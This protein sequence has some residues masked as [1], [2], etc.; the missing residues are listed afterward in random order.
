[1]DDLPFD[2]QELIWKKVHQS[3]MRN[4][5]DEGHGQEWGSVSGNITIGKNAVLD[6]DG[7]GFSSG[8]GP[9]PGLNQHGAPHGGYGGWIHLHTTGRIPYGNVSIKKTSKVLLSI[10]LRK[11]LW[12]AILRCSN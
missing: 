11:S 10:L 3:Y 6:G 12:R 5:T 4:I 1:M 2:I 9:H 7:L 8:T